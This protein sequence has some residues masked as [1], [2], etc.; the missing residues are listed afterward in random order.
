M[1]RR[2]HRWG[3]ARRLVSAGAALVLAATAL[4]ATGTG[5]QAG[6]ATG[7]S[8]GDKIRPELTRQLEG[9][10]EGDFWIHFSGKADLGKAAAIKDWNE[11]GAAV[12]AALKKT[13]AESQAKIRAEL[14]RSGTKYQ[15]FWATNAIKVTDGSLTMAQNFAAHSEVDGLYAPIEYKLPETTPGTDEKSANALE[16]G[17]ANINADDVWSQYGV[18]GAGITVASIDSGVQFDHPALVNSY[19]GNNGDGTFDHNYNWFDAAD[20]C[21]TAPCDSDGHGTHT[22]GTMAGADGANQIG[23]APEV[24][25]I[26]ANGCCPS[27]AA[28]VSSG[29]WML[30][31]TDLN[32]QNPDASKRPN[33]INNSWGTRT[34]SNEPFMEDVTNAWTASGIFGVWSNG[35]N[36]PSCQTSG[37]PGSLASNYSAGAYDVNN[38]IASFSSRGTGQNGEIKPNISAPGVNVRS[39]VPT[40]SYASISGTSM[41]A[42]HLAGAIALLWSA[43]PTLVGDVPATR[44]LL[45]DAAI[46]KGDTQCG[47]TTDDNNVYGEGRLDALALLAA[48]PIGDNGTLA[49]KVTDAATGAGIAGATVTLSGAADRTLTTGADGTYSSLLPAGDYQVVVSTFGYATRTLSATVTAN[50]TTTLDVALTAVPSVTVSGQVTDG[51]GHGWPLYAKVSVE[52]TPISDYTTPTTGRYSLSLPSGA[53]YRLTVEPQYAGYLTTTKEVTVGSGN[54]VA[55]IAVQANPEACTTAPGYTVSSDGEYETFDGTGVPD[56]WTVVDNAGT[57]QVW[58]FTDAGERGNLT[59]GSGNFA[60]IDSDN[61]GSGGQQ[62]TSLVSP[63]VDLTGVTTPV[64]RFNQDYNWLNSDRADVDLSLDGGTTWSNVLRQAADV[65][66][67]RVTEVPIP[68]AAGQ[69]QVRVRFHYY[70]ASWEWWWQVDNVLIGSTLVCKPVK[71]GLVLGHVR[72]KNDNSYVNGATVTSK[73]RPAEKA[74]TVATP[75]DTE[76]PDGFYWMFSSLTGKHPF[77]AGAGNYVSQT[78]QVTVEEDWATAANFQLAAG[79]L[80]VKPAS[81]TGTV[82][83][84]SGKVSKTF[85]VTNTGGAPVNAEFSERDGGFVLQ[86]ADGSQ[87]SQQALLGST[88]APVQRLTAATSFA[89]R[90]SGKSSTAIGAAAAP[91]ADPWTTIPGYPSNV[92]D[93]RV[94]SVDGKVYSIAGGDG[95]TSSAKN[96]RYDPIAQ[97]WTGIADLPGARNAMTV[98]VLD[99]KIVATGGWGAA[100]PDAATFSYDPA[101]NTWTRKADNPAPRSAAGQAVADGKLYAIG[102]CTTASCT[103]M[104]NSVVRYD[105]GADAWETLPAYPKSVAFL[106]CG[107]IDGTVYC[108][109]GNDGTTSQKAGYAFDPSAN[110]W[111]AIPDAPADSWASS[112]AVANGKLLVV[113]GSQGGAITNAGFAFDPATNSWANLPNANTPRYRGGAACGFYKIGGSS[114][115][116]TAT[117]DSEV[118]PGFS[119][120]SEAAADVSWLTVD[121]SKVTL[122]P[123]EKVT[124]TLTMTANVDQPGTYSASVAIKEDTPY[125]VEPVAVTMIAQPPN[126]WGKLSGTVSGKSCQGATAPLAGVTV[127]VDSWANSYTFTTDAQGRYAYWMDRRNNPLT[128]IVAK[129]GWKPQTRQTKI[130]SSTP[131]VE[132]FTLSPTRC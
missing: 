130:N 85:T 78:K 95:T 79:R 81:I 76:L 40:N 29:Q 71:G 118:L 45:D 67:P 104:S 5:A 115:S 36:G 82:R 46:D 93:N 123:G 122:A 120:C 106:S 33:I 132:D 70:E 28:L 77:T 3:P 61:Y 9:K 64:I 57:G 74:T 62:D 10:S 56:G 25:W 1:L 103:P 22:M 73:D 16:W 27:D 44:A 12:A 48:A 14:D 107:G 88:G 96:Y 92:M 39:S 54:A 20:E 112:Y 114:G 109:G 35:N 80:S 129:D 86:R 87:L 19:R 6:T 58:E 131:T 89:A 128:L 91:Q 117:K 125:T 13:A 116:F 72:D 98:G 30:E 111:T 51:S 97:A 83:M 127:Q 47:G 66:G 18:K 59:G 63:V 55:N 2:P 108:T 110:A 17:I 34:P 100:G 90:S 99:G 24:K 113:G 26:A 126:T 60:I 53:T 101:A 37:S 31:P 42:P 15:S 11:R 7:A 121:K 105:P 43:A 49:G 50:T 84:P 38:N 23:V 68:Q 69:S 4:A 21:A 75:D 8:A 94:V 52:G 102:G 119:E 124:V 32:G 65:R 41:A